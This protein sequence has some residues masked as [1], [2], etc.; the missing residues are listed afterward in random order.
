[1][2]EL[3]DD[4][5]MEISER[6]TKAAYQAFMRLALPFFIID[7][8]RR[9]FMANPALAEVFGYDDVRDVEDCLRRGA[10]LSA[11]FD[12]DALGRLYDRLGAQGEVKNWLMLGRDLGGKEVA[13]E[14]TAQVRRRGLCGQADFMEAVFVR[15]GDD[16]GQA[17]FLQ[18]AENEAKLAEKAKNEFLANISHELMTPLN[19]ING[20]L[21]MAVE[22]DG[23]PAELRENLALAKSAADGLFGVLSDLIAL[24]SLEAR[25]LTG[26][27]AQFSPELLVNALE[28][29][30]AAKAAEKSVELKTEL[31]RRR[32]Q[33]VDGGYSLIMMAM[34]KLVHNAL[35]FVDKGGKIV[36]RAELAEEEDS[37]LLRCLVTDDGPGLN[38]SLLDSPELFRQGDG[39]IN[40]RHGGLG[41]GLRLVSN[42]VASLG[43]RMIL[44]NQAGGGAEVGFTVPVKISVVDNE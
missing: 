19:I 36:I 24:S 30:F 14:M 1:M 29:Q 27:V 25:R 34:E 44:R 22:D 11:H 23:A 9:I 42:I 17:S 31:D 38:E 40:R 7:R 37:L 26:D 21:A 39:S 16:R 6:L 10:F 32:A 41:L 33:V 8:D 28:R 18:K 12:V 13:L 43:G 2:R 35:K 5:D 4:V 15:P 3:F 20:M